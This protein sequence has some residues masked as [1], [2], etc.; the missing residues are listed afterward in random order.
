MLAMAEPQCCFCS[1]PCHFVRV[2]RQKL[3]AQKY[4]P[5]Q[6]RAFRLLLKQ[7]WPLQLLQLKTVWVGCCGFYFVNPW[8]ECECEIVFVKMKTTEKLTRVWVLVTFLQ[9]TYFGSLLAAGRFLVLALA[10]AWAA[11]G[12]VFWLRER[13][14]GLEAR[15]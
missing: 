11:L 7:K 13:I 4:C 15:Q 9:T 2:L 10:L 8:C 3:I 5:Q 1:C 6:Q 12:P 14:W